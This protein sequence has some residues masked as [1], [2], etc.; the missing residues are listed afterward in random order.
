MN[1]KTY[2]D[3][4]SQKFL[5]EQLGV[6]LSFVNQMVTGKRPVP[7]AVCV[8]IEKV[9]QGLVTRQELRPDDYWL[10]WPDLEKPLTVTVEL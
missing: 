4:N 2:T 7:I 6:H 10:M 3:Q 9:T 8:A 1:L 5:A